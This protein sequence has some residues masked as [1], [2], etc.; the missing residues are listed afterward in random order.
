[1]ADVRFTPTT[2][3]SFYFFGRTF[4]AGWSATPQAVFGAEGPDNVLT[5]ILI[6]DPPGEA[7]DPEERIFVISHW[8]EPETPAS[9]LPSSRFMI[10]G[11]S[12]PHTERLV[13]DQGDTI[14]WRVINQS[15]AFHPMHLHGFYFNVDAL[16]FQTGDDLFAQQPYPLSVT[17]PLPVSMAL[18]MSW[19]AHEPGNWLFHCHL[20]RHMSWVQH[21]PAGDDAGHGHPQEAPEGVDLMGGMVLG[22]TVRPDDD[23]APA[24]DVPRRTLRLHIGR[25]DAVF[26]EHPGYGFV[27]QEGPDPP[28]PDSIRFPGSPI[29]LTRG[30]PTEIIV[31]NNTDVPLGV[32]WH[33]LELESRADG[34]PGW[35]GMPGSVVPAVAPGD[36]LAVRMTPPRAGTFM[37]HVHSE[38]GHQLAQGLYGPFL[39]LEPGQEWDRE[40]DRVFLLGAL[41][42]GDDAPPAI[43]GQRDPPPMDV[44]AGRT[45]RL[46]F[47]NISPDENKT[48]RLLDGDT[49]VLWTQAAKDGADLPPSR[50]RTVPANVQFFDVG[51]TFDVLWTPEA[52]GERT[53]R[54]ITTHDPGV[55]PFRRDV[56][57]PDTTDIPIRVRAAPAGQAGEPSDPV[58]PAMDDVVYTLA[59]WRVRP[60]KEAEFVTA[61]QDLGSVF[62]RLPDPPGTGTLLRS[63]ADPT[64][65][66]SFGPWSRLEAVEAMRADPDAQAAIRRLVELCTD[67]TPATFRLVARAEAPSPEP[68]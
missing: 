55:A 64:L 39:V 4:E 9:W 16:T 14:R 28:A 29:V 34:V 53:L 45:Y 57:P 6:V 51:N 37:Y 52:A 11:R 44:Q 23:Y 63:V 47:I 31:R 41:G 22:I 67:A 20:M 26:G 68:R 32:H 15:G 1:V 27:L 60:G 17:A 2:P 49:P 43:N 10:N 50:V 5:G 65:F 40:M 66:Y 58:K 42:G 12:W 33:G 8:A 46:R 25:R 36:S 21:A 24:L 19:V 3:G 7:P 54:I 30:E 56:P 48:I 18:R 62:A 13:Y 35:S 59:E 61:W 38:P